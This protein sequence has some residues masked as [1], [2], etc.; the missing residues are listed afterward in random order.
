[1]LDLRLKKPRLKLKNF[2]IQQVQVIFI[3]NNLV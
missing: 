2:V 1:M 3:V